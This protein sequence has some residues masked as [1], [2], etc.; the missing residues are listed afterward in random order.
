MPLGIGL[1]LDLRN[2]APW[3]VPDDRLMARTIDVV[4]HAEELGADSVWA[5]EHHLFEDGYLGQPLTLG[6]VLAAR[7]GRARIGTAVLVAPLR[8]PRHIAEQAALVDAVSGGRL[9]LGLG[10]GYAAA[11][12]AAFGAERS[13]RFAATDAAFR[14]VQRLL[15]AGGLGPEPVQR[16]VPMWLGY[17]G[18]RGAARAGRLGAGLLTLNRTSIEPYLTALRE[19]GHPPGAAR[20]AGSVDLIVSRDPERAWQRIKPHYAHQLRTYLRAH[21]PAAEIP[22]AALSSRFAAT[23]RDLGSVRLS[24]LTPEEAVAEIA[25]RIAGVPAAH[26]YTWASIAGM[27]DDLVDEHVELL[28]RDVAPRLR[29]A[30]D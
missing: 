25:Q 18:P 20:M 22:Q 23:R 9:E 27:P 3:R 29:R 13:G 1:F 11:E 16:P 7:T 2:P 12:F 10:A 4:R 30:G 21:D 5:T 17:Q 28:L 19:H 6:A 15:T 14:E 24:V 26:I 8:H